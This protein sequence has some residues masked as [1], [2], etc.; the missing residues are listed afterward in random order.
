MIRDRYRV[1]ALLQ[2]GGMGTVYEVMDSALNIRCALKEM[3]PY[4]GTPGTALPQLRD[5]FQQ[6]AQLLAGLRHPNL[7]RV[8][9]HF[10]DDG[11]AY[12]VMDFVNGKGLDEIIAEEGRLAEDKVLGW[13]AQLI[14]A[15]AH[16]HAH[17]VIHRDVKPQNVMITWQGQAMLVDFGLAKLVDPDDPRTRTV[18]QGL[19]TPEYAPPEQYHT[20]QGRTDPRTDIYSLGATLYH[21]LVGEPP[22]MVSERVVDPEVLVPVRTIRPDVSEA[23]DRVLMKALALRPAERFQSVGRLYYALFGSPLPKD[24]AEGGVPARMGKTQ[25]AGSPDSTVMLPWL[26]TAGLKIG[27][28]LRLGLAALGLVVLVAILLLVISRVNME[29]VRTAA[30]A[31]T[32]PGTV[33]ATATSTATSTPTPTRPATETPVPAVP[34]LAPEA[35]SL[36]LT[37][38]DDPDLVATGALLTYTLAYTNAGDE[39]ATGVLVADALDPDVVYVGASITPTRQTTSTLSWDV[40]TLAPAV[41]SE[42]VISVTVPCGLAQGSVLT[43]TA[44]LDSDEAEPVSVTQTTLV[45]QVSP[46]CLP[47][48]PTPT[49]TPIPTS[50]PRRRTRTPTSTPEPTRTHTPVPSPTPTR[51]RPSATPESPTSTTAAAAL[52]STPTLE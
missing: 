27:R 31:P 43:N 13:A 36:E 30:A 19:G 50:A 42:I 39:A 11:N 29:S 15:L 18:M 45:S 34:V 38:S 16:C 22:P 51:P 35:A 46:A 48:T 33:T 6:E 23:T 12:L 47:P 5:Q 32:L 20:K 40:G 2:H 17:G 4:P 9:N 3:V 10:E 37:A 28:R 49:L 52:T 21:A 44:T 14:Q 26:T 41:S 1:V 25:S 24:G 8:S 7:T